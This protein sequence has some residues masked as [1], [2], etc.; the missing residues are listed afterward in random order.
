M[1]DHSHD[2]R[3]RALDAD[4]LF[5]STGSH[6][7]IEDGVCVMEAVSFV[8]G[9][10]WSDHPTCASLV[11][12]DFLRT[13]NDAMTD[14]DRQ[15][16]VPL[17]PRLIGTA[18]SEADELT[19][20]W[21]AIDWY[22]RVLAP[23]WLRLAGLTAEADA[24]EATAP[25]VDRQSAEAAQDALNKGRA[26]AYAARAAAGASARAYAAWAAAVSGDAAGAGAAAAAGDA[27]RDVDWDAAGDAVRAAAGA[28]AGAKAA[29][30]AVDGAKLRPTVER[31]Q[32]SAL[33]LV[34]R[35]IAVGQEAR[36]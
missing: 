2:T 15:M 3:P 28:A 13:W 33:D 30:W 8:A 1:Y 6:A 34:E 21:L 29:V 32:S 16:L 35:M 11:I 17:I 19:R 14:D 18:G 12:G 25:I 9:E 31:L 27:A 7:S 10:P 24:I 5:L 22:C 23:A 20:S 36:P 4:G 26:R